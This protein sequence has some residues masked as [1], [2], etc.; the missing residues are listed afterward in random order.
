M[1]Y[2]SLDQSLTNLS[3]N[4]GAELHSFYIYNFLSQMES[5][6]C[7]KDNRDTF[8]L[9]FVVCFWYLATLVV[10]CLIKVTFLEYTFSLIFILS[11]TYCITLTIY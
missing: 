3:L 7:L 10:S 6:I 1:L 4:F 2:A 8:R 5:E 11:N 9:I